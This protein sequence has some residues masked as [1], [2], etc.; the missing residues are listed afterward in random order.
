MRHRLKREAVVALQVLRFLL[1]VRIFLQKC[2]KTA[3]FALQQ[4]VTS[5]AE[6]SFCFFNS[7]ISKEVLFGPGSGPLSLQCSVDLQASHLVNT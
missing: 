4:Q 7:L 5:E 2:V 1:P 6:V 3:R